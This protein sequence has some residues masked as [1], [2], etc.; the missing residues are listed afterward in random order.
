MTMTRSPEIAPYRLGDLARIPCVEPDPVE[1]WAAT[2][3]RQA[4]GIR[5]IHLDGKL[6]A[7]FGYVAI[8]CR[9]VD[10]FAVIDREACAGIGRELAILI[11]SQC[12]Q[13]MRT[14]GFTTVSASCAANDR[15]AQVFLRSIG[16]RQVKPA[17]GAS[18]TYLFGRST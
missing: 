6:V 3:E 5:S 14:Y 8:T 9:E 11:R 17:D 16:Y 12:L 13:W 7:C 2:T 15:A 10:C 1:G 18:L 4:H